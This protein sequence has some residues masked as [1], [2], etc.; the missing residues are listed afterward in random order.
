MDPFHRTSLKL[1]NH[2]CSFQILL[3]LE[4]FN[5]KWEGHEL[6]NEFI[7][8]VFVEQPLAL[9]DLLIIGPTTF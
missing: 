6:L 3:D 7:M 9:Q 8:T 4:S 1:L 2:I 5:K